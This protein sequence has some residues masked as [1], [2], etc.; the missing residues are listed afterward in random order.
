ML[1]KFH[2]KISFFVDTFAILGLI[3]E[4]DNMKKEIFKKHIID[5]EVLRTE[6]YDKIQALYYKI[7]CLTAEKLEL[8]EKLFLMQ[9]N[10]IRKLD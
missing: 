4:R 5:D 1:Y 2:E 3:N 6:M 8:V 10:F 7:D 9:E